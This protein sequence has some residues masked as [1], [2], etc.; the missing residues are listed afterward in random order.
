LPTEEEI[1][2]VSGEGRMGEEV[3]QHFLKE[4]NGKVG[5]REKVEEVLERQ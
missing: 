3:V 4:K 1:L 2:R 5:V